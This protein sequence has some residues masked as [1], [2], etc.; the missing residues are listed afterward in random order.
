MSE[1]PQLSTLAQQ[2]V[3]KFCS[4]GY[5]LLRSVAL[6]SIPTWS[7]PHLGALTCA[8]RHGCMRMEKG[9][10]PPAKRSRR[11]RFHRCNN[12]SLSILGKPRVLEALRSSYQLLSTRR[13]KR[14]LSLWQTPSQLNNMACSNCICFSKCQRS[15]TCT[16]RALR[17]GARVHHLC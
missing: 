14:S 10:N 16:P 2:I 4:C 11:S 7:R 6:V 13:N 9:N 12:P 8:G 3:F 5:I 15:V 17:S 1:N